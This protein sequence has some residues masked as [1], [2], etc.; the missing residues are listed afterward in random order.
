MTGSELDGLQQTAET[1]HRYLK[2]SVAFSEKGEWQGYHKGFIRKNGSWQL[3]LIWRS[4]DGW[5]WS[6]CVTFDYSSSG[7]T[8]CKIFMD[9]REE[10]YQV[11]TIPSDCITIDLTDP[12]SIDRITTV[13]RDLVRNTC[14]VKRERKDVP[15][16]HEYNSGCI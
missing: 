4:I 9:K 16:I 14:R 11:I 13:F 1:F 15:T 12:E 6:V 2:D 5:E 8:C 7:T 3:P 10:W